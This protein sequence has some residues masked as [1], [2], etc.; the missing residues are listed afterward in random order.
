MLKKFWSKSRFVKIKNNKQILKENRIN[1]LRK[2]EGKVLIDFGDT[3]K[4][5]SPEEYFGFHSLLE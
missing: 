4:K 1:K 5:V 2:I 3:Y